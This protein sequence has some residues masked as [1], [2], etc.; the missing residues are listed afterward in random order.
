MGLRAASDQTLHHAPPPASTDYATTMSNK[1]RHT[2]TCSA[3]TECPHKIATCPREDAGEKWRLPICNG[4]KHACNISQLGGG[5]FQEARGSTI[6]THH[7][8]VKFRNAEWPAV[9]MQR[10]T[11]LL[12]H[13]RCCR[14]ETRRAPRR[15]G[16]PQR[17]G[18]LRHV[19]KKANRGHRR[20]FPQL[21]RKKTAR[22]EMTQC[23]DC[24]PN[25]RDLTSRT[26]LENTWP[27]CSHHN[28]SFVWPAHS[29]KR[30]KGATLRH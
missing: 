26:V 28:C 18:A 8:R 17:A 30:R 12:P 7:S 20:L 5:S 2:T 1:P 21:P 15:L 14:S 4:D 29:G 23:D 24:Q 25:T 11:L 3:Q 13:G 10:Q 16:R 27:D 6:K 22:G 9:A 19:S